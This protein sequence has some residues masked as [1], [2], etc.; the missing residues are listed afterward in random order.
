VK[1]YITAYGPQGLV[2]VN[3]ELTSHWTKELDH[4]VRDSSNQ[5]YRD[6]IRRGEDDLLDELAS[7]KDAN[8][9]LKAENLKLSTQSQAD[10]TAI[11]DLKAEVESLKTL[12]HTIAS[13]PV[14]TARPLSPMKVDDIPAEPRVVLPSRDLASRL[15]AASTPAKGKGKAAPRVDDTPQLEDILSPEGEEMA[16]QFA[17]T[18]S[19]T[20]ANAVI[21]PAA[22]PS[23]YAKNKPIY[24]GRPKKTERS[25]KRTTYWPTCTT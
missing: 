21:E 10:A 9:D 12:A 16:M 15:Q 17:M 3:N 2:R 18:A 13:R 14:P 24:Y 7:L 20:Y 11:N 5:A 6:G 23:N 25:Q 19:R 8:R 1:H 22:G 4:L